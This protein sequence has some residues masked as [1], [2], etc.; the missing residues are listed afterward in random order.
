MEPLEGK[1]PGTPSPETVSTRRQRI[2][3]LARKAPQMAFT[4][5][6]HHIDIDW[7]KR[8]TCARARTGPRGGRTDGGGL[9]GGPGGQPPVA[10][11]PLQVRTYQAPPVRRVHI[12]KG[13]GRRR[14]PSAFPP[15]RTRSFSAR[16]RWSWRPSTNRTFWTA[17]SA[18]GPG[19]RPTR[20]WRRSGTADGDRRV[21]PGDRHPEVFRCSGPW[22][23]AAILRRRVRDGVLL[24]LI[25]KWLKAGVLEEGAS[26]I[27]K[28]AARRAG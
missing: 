7:L 6:A 15:S 9:R 27:P 17:R 26:R 23:S 16:W 18:S 13:T 5:L 24:R 2:A 19:G 11:G 20:L 28:P 10:A 12:P 22:P 21:G 3:E 14:G 25:D 1:T 4:T 8:R